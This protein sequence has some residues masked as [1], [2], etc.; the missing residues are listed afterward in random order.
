MQ[1]KIFRVLVN[2]YSFYSTANKLAYC[3]GIDWTVILVKIYIHIHT[4]NFF[5][6]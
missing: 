5:K 1:I 4:Y 6:Q 2:N 3:T